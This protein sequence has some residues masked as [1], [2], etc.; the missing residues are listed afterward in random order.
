MRGSRGVT[1]KTRMTFKYYSVEQP[2]AQA[3]PAP[4][5]GEGQATPPGTCSICLGAFMS[6]ETIC[7]VTCGHSFHNSCCSIWLEGHSTC[8]MCRADLNELAGQKFSSFDDALS[9][10]E[11]GE[12]VSISEQT[13]D[14]QEG[15]QLYVGSSSL[16]LVELVR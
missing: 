3:M 12:G 11:R 10:S 9:N 7:L 16:R 6:G 4:I 1:Q 15:P 5:H 14:I 2:L 8:P 13:S